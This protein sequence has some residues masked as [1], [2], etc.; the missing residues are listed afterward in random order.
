MRQSSGGYVRPCSTASKGKPNSRPTAR[1]VF[2]SFIDISVL[3]V[4][5]L[6]TSVLGLTPAQKALLT[7]LGH[8]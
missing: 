3:H 1:R 8:R 4:S 7:R 5:S 2:Q 6:K